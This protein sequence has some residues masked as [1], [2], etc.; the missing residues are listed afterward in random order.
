ME[1]PATF[2]LL[3]QAPSSSLNLEP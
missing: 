3:P 1:A 2:L